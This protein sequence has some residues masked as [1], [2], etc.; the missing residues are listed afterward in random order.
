MFSDDLNLMEHVSRVKFVF[1]WKPFLLVAKI[2]GLCYEHI[3]GNFNLIQ[4]KLILF[5]IICI[6][7]KFGFDVYSFKTDLRFK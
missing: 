1:S 6:Y 5:Q 2:I 7:N 4:N 3:K